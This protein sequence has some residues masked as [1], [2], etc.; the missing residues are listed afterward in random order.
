MVNLIRGELSAQIPHNEMELTTC[1]IPSN[2]TVLGL[3]HELSK[4]ISVAP[5]TSSQ[6]SAMSP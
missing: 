5:L 4:Q 1:K 3:I 6:T 2:L